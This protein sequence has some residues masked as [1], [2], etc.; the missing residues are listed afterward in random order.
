MAGVTVMSPIVV[1][2]VGLN[3]LRKENAELKDALEKATRE[4]DHVRAE[5]AKSKEIIKATVEDADEAVASGEQKL[6]AIQVSHLGRRIC[7]PQD[8]RADLASRQVGRM[9]GCMSGYYR[10]FT[11]SDL[12]IPV[13]G[14]F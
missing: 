6:R 4:V 5:L 13:S 11:E 9:V 1:A 2:S 10:A 12:A 14:D 8:R 7:R 3:V